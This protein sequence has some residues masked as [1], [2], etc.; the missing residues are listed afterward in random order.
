LLCF[1]LCGYA[2]NAPFVSFVSFSS[3][4]FPHAL[5]HTTLCAEGVRKQAGKKRA[6][7]R[8]GIRTHSFDS[9]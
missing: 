8:N 9:G 1:F 7:S 6:K 3:S 2:A 5:L 4:V